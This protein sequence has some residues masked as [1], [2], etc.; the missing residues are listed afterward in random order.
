MKLTSHTAAMHL[1]IQFPGNGVIP[2]E[3]L[4]P[5]SQL[6]MRTA[7]EQGAET[8]MAHWQMMQNLQHINK[9]RD[10]DREQHNRLQ[11]AHHLEQCD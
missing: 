9:D 1:V 6:F 11:G 3:R 8:L 10:R 4:G 5:R 2:R 7:T